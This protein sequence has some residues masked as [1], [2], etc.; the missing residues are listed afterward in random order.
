[1]TPYNYTLTIGYNPSTTI[2]L[3]E[4]VP[5][6]VSTSTDSYL[7]L[8]FTA[9]VTGYYEIITKRTSGDP[10]FFLFDSNGYLITS[11]DDSGGNLNARLYGDLEIA[12]T[13]YIA[14]QGYNGNAATFTITIS[15]E[16]EI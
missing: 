15:L 14:V 3:I 16:E 8:Q 11:D 12:K 2:G 5:Y 6:S 10:M 7:M 4:G 13:Y 9:S 1:M